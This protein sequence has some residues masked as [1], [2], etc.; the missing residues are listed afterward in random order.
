MQDDRLSLC[1]EREEEV[2]YE[3]GVAYQESFDS[4]IAHFTR[5][6]RTRERFE[7]D[8]EDNPMTLSLV[9][10]VYQLAAAGDD[11]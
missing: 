4:A 1:G 8:V 9:E 10:R 6:L 11:R 2:R 3:Q 5:C 7:T